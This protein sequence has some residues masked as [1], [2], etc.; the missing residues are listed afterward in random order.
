MCF[1]R[2]KGEVVSRVGKILLRGQW[3]GPDPAVGV[4]TR[5]AAKL[6]PAIQCFHRLHSYQY[7]HRHHRS[8]PFFEACACAPTHQELVFLFDQLQSGGE[9]RSI[10]VRGT[11]V[12]KL[13]NQMFFR[14]LRTLAAL[15]LSHHNL[16]RPYGALLP[17]L[18]VR[19]DSFFVGC[20][21]HWTDL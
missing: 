15:R 13:S 20:C 5:V 21:C 8:V 3:R 4:Q 19:K 1:S 2:G 14:L 7:P 9:Q 6:W 10:A 18:F 11:A 17:Y 12:N 16:Q